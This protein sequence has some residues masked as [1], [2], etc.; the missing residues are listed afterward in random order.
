MSHS[1]DIHDTLSLAVQH[2]QAGRLEQAESLY[3]QVLDAFPENEDALHFLGVLAYQLE[4]HDTAIELISKAVRINP[5]LAEAHYNLGK[6][7][8][9]QGKIDEAVD[10]YRRTIAINP[11]VGEAHYNLAIAFANMGK[12]DEAVASYRRAI[13]INPKDAD[14]YYNMGNALRDQKKLDE[15]ITAYQYALRINPQYAKVHNNLGIIFKTQGRLDEAITCYE[16]AI[17]IDANYADA[18]YN[19]ANA[20]DDLEDLNSAIACYQRALAI[21]PNH[22]EAHNNLGNAFGKQ[23]KLDEAIVHYQRAAELDPANSSSAHNNLGNTFGRQDKLDEAI[24]HYQRAAEL[25]PANSSAKHMVAAL[26]GQTTEIAPSKYIKNLF[27]QSA[28]KFDHQ[29]VKEL[30]YKS[31]TALRQ[32]LD[33]LGN[34]HFSNA[35]DLGCGTGLSGL[36]FHSL[37]DRLT[38]IDLSPKMI[39]LAKKRNVYNSL[40]VGDIVELLNQSNEKYDLFIATDVLVYIGNLRPI[41]TAVRNHALPGAYFICLTESID[42]GDYILRQTGR[43][44]HSRPHIRSLAD[45]HR[46]KIEYCE[47]APIRVEK[48]QGIMGDHLILKYLG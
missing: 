43:Y 44:A 18:H 39:E 20:L 46:F 31:P 23:G 37:I 21:N 10:S 28:T 5:N 8:E 11:G 7:F 13:A 6:V 22:A 15:A 47:P 1:K 26:T 29:L 12:L 38:G 24:V 36:A 41:F 2:H 35:I 27:D 4:E 9:A 33:G 3:R 16:R 34:M 30:D 48:G 14:A 17:A 45:E 42:E 32:A 40:H 19:L 25:D